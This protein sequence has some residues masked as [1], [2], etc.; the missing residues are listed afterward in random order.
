MARGIGNVL[1]GI[2]D[3]QFLDLNGNFRTLIHGHAFA[4]VVELLTRQLWRGTCFANP[5][6]SEF[7]LAYFVTAFRRLSALALP[8]PGPRPCCLRLRLRVRVLRFND[9]ESARQL[10]S[11]HGRSLAAGIVDRM[12]SR[13]GLAAPKPELLAAVQ[14]TARKNGLLVIADEVLNLRQSFRG[15]PRCLALFRTSSRWARSSAA[16]CQL[17]QSEDGRR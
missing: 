13:G 1:F 9:A 2:D 16:V 14:D 4:P 7:D 5:T 6:E 11:F 8:T 12:P 17:E 3:N 15:R 10:L